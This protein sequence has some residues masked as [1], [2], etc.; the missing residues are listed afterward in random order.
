MEIALAVLLVLSFPVVAIA[1]LVVAI[2]ARERVRVLEQRFADFQKI[3]P[4]SAAATMAPQAP[5]TP[6]ATPTPL[7]EPPRPAAPPPPAIPAD[8]APPPKAGS[9]RVRTAFAASVHGSDHAGDGLRG[10]PR[11]PMD[12]LGW[13]RR[14]CARLVFCVD[15]RDLTGNWQSISLIGLGVV[16]MEI[17][18]FY[19]RLLFPRRIPAAPTPT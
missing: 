1:G 9:R 10:T 2:G 11:H 18:I 12:R 19:Q 14:A 5:S 15:M 13:R 7:A 3:R 8:D 4:I 6:V 16:L 17:G